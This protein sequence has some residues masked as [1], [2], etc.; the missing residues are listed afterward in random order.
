MKFIQAFPPLLAYFLLQPHIWHPVTWGLVSIM[1]QKGFGDANDGSQSSLVAPREIAGKGQDQRK[2]RVVK[3]QTLSRKS[4]APVGRGTVEPKRAWWSVRATSADQLGLCLG[5][6][7][8]GQEAAAPRHDGHT[9]QATAQK[10][11][12]WPGFQRWYQEEKLELEKY[13]GSRP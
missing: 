3:T 4:W 10:P 8:T 5:V 12:E 7:G 11:C 2:G 13:L 1:V 9:T 6:P